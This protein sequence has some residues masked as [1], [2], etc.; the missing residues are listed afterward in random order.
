MIHVK[1]T[2][3]Q[4]KFAEEY[5]KDLN[6]TRA[7]KAS[8]PHV[9]KDS[10]ARANASRLLTKANVRACIDAQ[11][12]QM[13]NENT[14]DAQEIIEYLSSVMRGKQKEEKLKGIGEGSQEI[15]EVAVSARDRL[16]AAELL[17][18][19]YALFSDNVN[20][21]SSDI[22]IVIGGDND[23]DNDTNT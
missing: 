14:A 11:L 4:R 20:L 22:N 3:K 7:Y 5:L 9:K 1:L 2:E 12:E 13:H 15:A 23:G 17:G 10:V 18:R 8:Y 16:K 21:T 6:G 19:R